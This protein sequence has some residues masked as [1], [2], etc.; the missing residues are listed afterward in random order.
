[1]LLTPLQAGLLAPGSLTHSYL[2]AFPSSSTRNSI[3]SAGS[4]WQCR[5]SSPVT[6]AGPLP[7]Q[8]SASRDSLLSLSAPNGLYFTMADK[9]VKLPR[10]G[11]IYFNSITAS[12]TFFT[13]SL[14]AFTCLHSPELG[15]VVEARLSIN[16]R[17]ISSGF[18]ISEAIV[19]NLS[20]REY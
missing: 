2:P 8:H 17:M 19:C 4:Q 16:A 11:Q 7:N 12:S 13:S 20:D 10:N 9:N 3:L 18:L 6:A 14:T 5:L 1:V 15:L